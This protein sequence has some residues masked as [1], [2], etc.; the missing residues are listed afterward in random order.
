MAFRWR[1]DIGPLLVV[2]GS[3]LPV[4]NYCQCCRVG[5]P[6]TKLSGSAHEK[7]QYID[8]PMQIRPALIRGYI[9]LNTDLELSECVDQAC[10]K[11][12]LFIRAKWS[13]KRFFRIK[14]TE[15]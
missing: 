5:P 11:M 2:F 14:G 4:L 9:M 15:L 7:N 10:R 1:A 8:N 13:L 3:A 6:L 12:C